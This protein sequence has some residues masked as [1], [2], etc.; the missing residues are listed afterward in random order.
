ML[1]ESDDD[2]AVVIAL[3]VSSS[4][5][6]A[7]AEKRA[8]GS[9]CLHMA[10]SAGRLEMVKA[11][12]GKDASLVNVV[13]GEVRTCLHLACNAGHLEVVKALC[14]V[15]GVQ[16][17]NKDRKGFTCLALAAMSGHKGIVQVLLA[18]DKSLASIRDRAGKSAF[19]LAVEFGKT[20]GHWEA[21]QALLKA[22]PTLI[23]GADPQQHQLSLEPPTTSSTSN[24][25][26]HPL[27]CM[28]RNPPQHIHID[29]THRS[30]PCISLGPGRGCS[31]QKNRSCC[32]TQTARVQG[33][34]FKGLMRDPD[35]EGL[36]SRV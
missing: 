15:E 35:H 9:N 29:P 14:E 31:A 5:P 8:D 24:L 10:C 4:G 33:L 22:D 26:H 1:S 2:A 27:E 3:F 18:K 17:A 20:P 25:E 13:D 36:G 16:L 30:R 7:L 21:A 11:V 6:E 32:E 34:G 28:P 19:D 23:T 12:I